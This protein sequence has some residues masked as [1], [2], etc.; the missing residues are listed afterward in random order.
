MGAAGRVGGCVG[1]RVGSAYAYYQEN[2][3]DIDAAMCERYG[4]SPA[5][6]LSTV[7]GYYGGQYISNFNRFSKLYRV[8]I[9]AE[10][11]ARVTPESFN[12]LYVRTCRLWRPRP[13]CGKPGFHSY[14]HLCFLPREESAVMGL[15]RPGPTALPLRPVG[16]LDIFGKNTNAK[17]GACEAIEGTRDYAQAVRT[18]LI[19]TIA[20]CYYTLL[21]LD[22][23]LE[24]GERTLQSWDSSIRVLEALKRAG[25]AND[26]AVLQARSNWMQLGASV[27][28]LRKSIAETENTLSALLALPSRWIVRGTLA[29]AYFPRH[30][31]VG[32]PAQ[33]LSNRPDV[34]RAEHDLARAFYNTNV[35]R[36]AFYPSLTFSGTLGWT[37][38]GGGAVANPA[39]W[40]ANVLGSLVQQLFDKGAN[41]AALEIAKAQ[42]EEASLRFRQSLLDAGKEVNNALSHWQAAQQRV[43]VGAR[44]IETLREAVCRHLY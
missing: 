36:A 40:L 38:N 13:R 4:L 44:Q 43:D 25:Q 17:R 5:E 7:A 32:V 41:A 6:V 20:D 30:L 8:M 26:V 9:Q 37:N 19:A 24:T 29:E 28:S 2:I 35:A 31:S 15:Q 16:E 33:L 21:M 3:L 34:R 22:S 39:Q 12:H 42:Q 18:Q 1:G 10:P 14:R 23:Q 27:I 11:E